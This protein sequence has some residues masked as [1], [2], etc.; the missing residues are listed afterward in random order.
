[1]L[2]PDQIEKKYCLVNAFPSYCIGVQTASSSLLALK[3]LVAVLVLVTWQLT[4]QSVCIALSFI[5]THSGLTGIV[6]I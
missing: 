6:Q 2:N 3:C 4:L 1:M 5:A